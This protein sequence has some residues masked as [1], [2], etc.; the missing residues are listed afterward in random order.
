MEGRWVGGWVGD[1]PAEEER[2]EHIVQT[3]D[4]G[5][6]LQISILSTEALLVVE[7]V[8]VG[9]VEQGPKLLRFVLERCACRGE[10]RGLN[11]LL[12]YT[13]GVGGKRTKRRFE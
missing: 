2:F 5:G 10:K 12:C 9:K 4:L 11:E 6:I 13:G 1:V 7:V 3:F 8:R